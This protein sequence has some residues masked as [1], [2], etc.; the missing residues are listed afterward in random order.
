MILVTIALTTTA[1]LI[2]DLHMIVM[3]QE[4]MDYMNFVIQSI[5]LKNATEKW[6]KIQQA[7]NSYVKELL[8]T[9]VMLISVQL[10]KL[11][12]VNVKVEDK[13]DFTK[14]V[15]PDQAQIIVFMI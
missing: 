10:T 1:K 7:D 15:M 5:M 14:S 3:D 2:K 6:T 12:K 4:K 11:S 13:V 9:I 8:A